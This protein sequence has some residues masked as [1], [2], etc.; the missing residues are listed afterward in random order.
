MCGPVRDADEK[1]RQIV[2]AYGNDV[3]VYDVASNPWQ[4]C[5]PLPFPLKQASVVDHGNTFL[6]VGGMN[7]LVESDKLIKYN[8]EGNVWEVLDSTLSEG[9]GSLVAMNIG[10]DLEICDGC[11]CLP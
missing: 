5:T 6:L 10:P 8:A 1:V 7:N 2:V 4:A 3:E 11:T 9:L